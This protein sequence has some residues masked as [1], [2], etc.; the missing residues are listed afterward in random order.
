MPSPDARTATATLAPP[1]MVVFCSGLGTQDAQAGRRLLSDLEGR[2]LRRQLFVDAPA[3]GTHKVKIQLADSVF[4]ERFL[5]LRNTVVAALPR[6]IQSDIF[7]DGFEMLCLEVLLRRD[8]LDA[9]ILLRGNCD[10]EAAVGPWLA[11]QT[12]PF[13]RI[14]PEG[15][16]SRA[17]AFRTAHPKLPALVQVASDLYLSGAVLALPDYSLEKALQIAWDAVQ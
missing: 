2:G 14:A 1:E 13:L 16:P 5:A 15:G 11:S 3:E 17:L 10:F 4:P 12:A 7:R 6:G 8:N 9:I